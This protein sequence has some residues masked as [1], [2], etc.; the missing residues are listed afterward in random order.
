MIFFL[1][2]VKIIAHRRAMNIPIY[3]EIK[4]YSKMSLLIRNFTSTSG[5][6]EII[7][8]NREQHGA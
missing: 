8:R 2:Q 4:S 6:N 7:A 1:E 3:S 5:D